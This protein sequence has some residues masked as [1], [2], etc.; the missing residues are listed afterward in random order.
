M[1]PETRCRGGAIGGR[2][3]IVLPESVLGMP[4]YTYVVQYLRSRC[5]IV[6]VVSMPEDL[7]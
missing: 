2:M 7:F 6:G 5:T 3:G 4:T 1:S